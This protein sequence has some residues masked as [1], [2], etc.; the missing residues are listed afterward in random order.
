MNDFTKEELQLLFLSYSNSSFCIDKDKDHFYKKLQSMTDNYCTSFDTKK[1][2]E[3]HL[4]AATS[5]I[6][7]TMQLLG[8]RDE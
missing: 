6:G 4:T 5:L 3:S 1:I 8:M 2:A 7:H